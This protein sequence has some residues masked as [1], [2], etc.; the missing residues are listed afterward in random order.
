MIYDDFHESCQ[1]QCLFY[2]A[3]FAVCITL[4]ACMT[5]RII[6]GNFSNNGK[7]GIFI[8]GGSVE[9]IGATADNNKGD[10]FRFSE[11]ADVK[12][13]DLI[14]SGNDGLGINIESPDTA[15][16]KIA[17][18]IVYG[19]GREPAPD[20]WYKKPIPMIAFSVIAGILILCVRYAAIHYFG[21]SL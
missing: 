19:P 9:I 15:A 7:G 16:T 3:G 2:F 6:G 10:G 20:H 12:A 8:A 11:N 21:L 14:A 18:Q 13:K 1:R 5:N 4:G 17:D